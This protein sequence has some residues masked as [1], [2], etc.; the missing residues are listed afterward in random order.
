MISWPLSHDPTDSDDMISSLKAK[1]KTRQ[2]R[3]ALPIPAG[4]NQQHWFKV[5][6]SSQLTFVAILRSASCES[7]LAEFAGKSKGR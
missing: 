6:P 5:E 3:L 2:G 1:S 7:K 4:F